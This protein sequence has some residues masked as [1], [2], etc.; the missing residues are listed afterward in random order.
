MINLLRGRAPRPFLTLLLAATLWLGVSRRYAAALS[1]LVAAAF[2]GVSVAANDNVHGFRH[3]SLGALFVGI[4]NPQRD[5]I[6]RAVGPNADVTALWTGSSDRYTIW[7][8]EFFNRSVGRVFYTGTPLAGSLAQSPVNVDP[9][10]GLVRDA[11][12]RT[13]R[14]DFMLVD[15]SFVPEH[16]EA[17]ARGSLAFASSRGAHDLPED[18]GRLLVLSGDGMGVPVQRCRD[19]LVI[20]SA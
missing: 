6:D 14:V 12:G 16:H 10:S 15:G 11:D 1:A 4:G 7:L 17:S 13:V 19:P 2:L 8:N 9:R 5:W 3:A 18:C 20:E